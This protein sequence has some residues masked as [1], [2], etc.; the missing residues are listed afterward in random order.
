MPEISLSEI[1][2]RERIADSGLLAVRENREIREKSGNLKN[3]Q[4]GKS[5]KIRE[6][7]KFIILK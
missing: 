1:S 4:G 3:D 6:S 7:T 5:R 2:D